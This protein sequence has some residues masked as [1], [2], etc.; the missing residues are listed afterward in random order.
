MCVLVKVGLQ[1]I[2]TSALRPIVS[3]D[4]RNIEIE[5]TNLENNFNGIWNLQINKY[6]GQSTR[7]QEAIKR[8]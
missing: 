4:E 8:A 3:T 7:L 6:F 5:H 2:D 1:N